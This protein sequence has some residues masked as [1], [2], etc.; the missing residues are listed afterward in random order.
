M[1]PYKTL[2]LNVIKLNMQSELIMLRR[3]EVVEQQKIH[4]VINKKQWQ[5]IHKI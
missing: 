5:V 4:K 2:Q 3:K 1:F